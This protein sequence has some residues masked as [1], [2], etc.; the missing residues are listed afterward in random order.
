MK[1]SLGLFLEVASVM[2]ITLPV[3]YPI[4]TG[5][6]FNGIWFAVLMTLNMEMAL[7]APPVGLNL[8]VIQGIARSRLAPL[9]GA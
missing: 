1:I 4:I 7:I 9:S 2:V 3:L 6:G 8:Y 5:L